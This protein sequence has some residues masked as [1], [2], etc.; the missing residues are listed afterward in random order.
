MEADLR[1]NGMKPGLTTKQTIVRGLVLGVEIDE[2][3]KPQ[4][5]NRSLEGCRLIIES[6]GGVMPAFVTS[7]FF[8]GE[9]VWVGADMKAEQAF[10]VAELFA[11]KYGEADP[12]KKTSRH[13]ADCST[14][15]F[16]YN[17][18]SQGIKLTV[19]VSTE[20]DEGNIFIAKE[21][22]PGNELLRRKRRIEDL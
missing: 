15:E 21:P 7:R 8:D 12:G 19:T 6:I 13:C 20:D 16:E 5:E 14:T 3:S 4:P 22:D 2:C 10:H 11:A 17:W 1:L 9:L 18:R